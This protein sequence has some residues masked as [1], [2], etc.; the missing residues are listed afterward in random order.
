M[1][2]NLIDTIKRICYTLNKHSVEY[3]IVGGTAVAL[4]GYFR[5][6]TISS[7]ATADKP[8][9]DFW[10]NP[11]YKNYFSL[12]EALQEL[13]QDVISFKNEREPDPRK[14][15]FK[16]ES[17]DFTLDLLPKIKA[18]IKFSSAFA[19]KLTVHLA[20]VEIALIGYSD[21]I[22]D[23]ATSSRPKDLIDIRELKKRRKA[24]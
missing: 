24:E 9:L 5:H 1:E 21:L 22:N 19:N 20:E 7:G 8:D 12:L 14:A 13:G 2:N 10:Y 15:F 18:P 16:Y 23:K 4:H 3:M 17:E 11:S 6:S